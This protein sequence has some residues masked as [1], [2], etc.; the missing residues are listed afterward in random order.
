MELIYEKEEAINELKNLLEEED[1]KSNL[2]ERELKIGKENVATL[3]Q[4]IEMYE[5]HNVKTPENL[6]DKSKNDN[7]INSISCEASILKENVELKDQ[8]K[9]LTTNY[10]KLE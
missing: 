2:L 3:I 8:L 10:R 4:T 6:D 7:A 5:L 9:L 1:R